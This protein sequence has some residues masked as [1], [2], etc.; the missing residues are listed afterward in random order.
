MWTGGACPA[1]HRRPP[2]WAAWFSI[3]YSPS[4]SG[5]PPLP[6]RTDILHLVVLPG[7]VA[8]ALIHKVLVVFFPIN[9]VGAAPVQAVHLHLPHPKKQPGKQQPQQVKH[10]C[11]SDRL[12]SMWT[13]HKYL[14]SGPMDQF[15]LIPQA[16]V[17]Q[18]SILY[19][20]I[21]LI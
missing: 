17:C 19:V 12:L 18:N 5:A 6:H 20:P 2:P 9:W 11:Y 7:L 4:L 15:I 14:S 1:C 10:P 8:T 13:C 3:V 16:C 21:M